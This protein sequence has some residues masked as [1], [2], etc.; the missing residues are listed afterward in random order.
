MNF[1]ACD[2]AW[3]Y[4]FAQTS[5]GDSVLD[6]TLTCQGTVHTVTSEEMAA[7]NG[8]LTWEDVQQYQSEV[9]TLFC[10]AFL[11]VV[12]RKLL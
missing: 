3:L 6:Q 9:L 1:I 5:S 12:L 7:A 2:G 11:F 10:M 8:S 4:R